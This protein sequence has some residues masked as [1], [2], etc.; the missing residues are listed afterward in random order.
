MDLVEAD[1]QSVLHSQIVD[2]DL[3]LLA[4]ST[5]KNFTQMYE[6]YFLCGKVVF[7]MLVFDLNTKITK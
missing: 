5:Y 6:D 1:E 4:C 7:N 3:Q 2:S